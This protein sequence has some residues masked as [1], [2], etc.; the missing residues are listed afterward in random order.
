[1]NNYL[2]PISDKEIKRENVGLKNSV[3]YP[4]SHFLAKH[5]MGS[6]SGTDGTRMAPKK[7]G[8]PKKTDRAPTNPITN[9]IGIAV[10]RRPGRPRKY[11][12][13]D[14]NGAPSAI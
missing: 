4:S 1:M 9:N 6:K 2:A 13:L 5:H 10:K 7:R 3:Y 14:F 12:K 11:L 8:R